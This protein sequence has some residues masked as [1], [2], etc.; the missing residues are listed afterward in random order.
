MIFYGS[1]G[2]LRTSR[3]GHTMSAWEKRIRS[4]MRLLYGQVPRLS[5][6]TRPRLL[7]ALP[8]FI[9]LCTVLR[10]LAR[11]EVMTPVEVVLERKMLLGVV[12][13]GADGQ[14]LYLGCSKHF[15][16]GGVVSSLWAV[17]LMMAV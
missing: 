16:R 9:C 15:Q 6:P 1:S 12:H 4:E 10:Y 13:A 2:L 5:T 11:I 8:F 14:A 7:A 3:Y 17:V